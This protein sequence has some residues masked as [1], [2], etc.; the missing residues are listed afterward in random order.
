MLRGVGENQLTAPRRDFVSEVRRG[1][2][3]FGFSR[4]SL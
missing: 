2:L 3:F 1:I 4:V